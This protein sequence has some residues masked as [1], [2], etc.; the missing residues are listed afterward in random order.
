MQNSFGKWS[1][2]FQKTNIIESRNLLEDMDFFAAD[3][4]LSLYALNVFM[5]GDKG[6]LLCELWAVTSGGAL[7]QTCTSIRECTDGVLIWTMSY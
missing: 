1:R 5:I 4:L 3:I 2:R 6:V 7:Y